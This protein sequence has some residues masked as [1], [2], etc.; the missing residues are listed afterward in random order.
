VTATAPA[1]APPAPP[2]RARGGL[3]ELAR[4]AA[5]PLISAAAITALLSAWVIAG[6]AGSVTRVRVQIG[7]AA[8]PMRAY[9][10]SRAITIHSAP[11]YLTIRNLSG[12]P[13]ELL[14]V[15]T[16][17]TSHVVLAGPPGPHGARHTLAG[18][19]IPAHRSITL[20]PLGADVVL[21]DPARY[22]TDMTVP[23]TLIFRNAGRV[24]VDAAVTAPGSP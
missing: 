2:A 12:E 6:G 20:T 1:P 17:L 24:Q 7:L 18:L 4:A 10:L 9:T 22:E 13:D 5:A 16:P 15:Q 11:T 23:L 14:S 21:L 8:V 19:A 3:A